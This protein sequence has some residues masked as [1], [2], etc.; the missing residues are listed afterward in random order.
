MRGGGAVPAP[1]CA[2]A[3]PAHHRPRLM[4]HHFT[5]D[6][7]EY[8]QVS[9]F[10]PHV[11]RAAWDSLPSRV[12][13]G[14][15]V[16]LDL[17]SEYEARGTFF[18]LG[19]VAERHPGL[20]REI[21][22]GGHEV[23]SHGWSHR[24]VTQL[25]PEQFRAEVRDSKSILEDVGGAPVLGYRAPSFSIVP[26][27]EWA[28]DVLAEE[29]YRYDSSLFPIRRPGYGFPGTPAD[30]HRIS[31]PSGPLEE[32]PPATL[33]VAGVNL[34]AGGGGYFRL[35]PYALASAAFRAAERRGAPATF[36][37]HPWE[38]DPE[39]PRIDVPL[40]TRVRHYG[41]LRK[42]VPRLRKLLSTFRF[43]PIAHTLALEEAPCPSRT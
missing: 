19:W 31:R 33:P 13:F 1:G 30:P 40:K 28:L 24:R 21:A 43:Q 17:L 2:Q 10:E 36:Y 5:V 25:A 12:E 7:E 26:G 29:G 6:V 23:A 9:A 18:V 39:Q 35:L 41:A 20:V 14:T 3:C 37:I 22:G 15:R 27:R 16:I 34:P 42:T 4:R 8:F 32:V 11:D 38:V